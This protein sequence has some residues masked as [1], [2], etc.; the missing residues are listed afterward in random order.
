MARARKEAE[1]FTFG[2]RLAREFLAMGESSKGR[3]R[4][5]GKK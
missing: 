1:I 4:E 3:K 2:C 5:R